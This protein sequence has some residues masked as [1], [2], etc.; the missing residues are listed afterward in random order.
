M[1][2]KHLRHV[3]SNIKCIFFTNTVF[4]ECNVSQHPV[5]NNAPFFEFIFL[6]K[7]KTVR[8]ELWVY[9][10]DSAFICFTTRAALLIHLSRSNRWTNKVNAIKTGCVQFHERVESFKMSISSMF[11]TS[12]FRTKNYKALF[13]LW[14]FLAPKFGTK[15]H[16]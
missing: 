9:K 10:N 11:Y 15:M 12:V 6:V 7:N 13:W 1:V 8:R 2:V 3:F 5:A 4:S 14:D 16:A